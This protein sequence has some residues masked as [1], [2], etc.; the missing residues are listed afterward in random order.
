MDLSMDDTKVSLMTDGGKSTDADRSNQRLSRR[1][2]ALKGLK[3]K[4]VHHETSFLDSG[5]SAI[6]L[7]TG[8]C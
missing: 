7:G 3:C 6:A 5:Y 8:S 4:C 2:R 1:E